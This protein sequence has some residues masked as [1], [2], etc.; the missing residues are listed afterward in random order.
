LNIK[1]ISLR[2]SNFCLPLF[3]VSTIFA[4]EEIPVVR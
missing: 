3:Q 4:I 2:L 1:S